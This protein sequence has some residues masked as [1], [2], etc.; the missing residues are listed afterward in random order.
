MCPSC[1]R[2]FS[3][4]EDLARHIPMHT[5]EKLYRCHQCLYRTDSRSNI[6]RHHRTHTGEKRH[7]CPVCP[8]RAGQKSDIRRHLRV[9]A[10]KM[11]NNVFRCRLCSANSPSAAA[12]ARHI[13][14][15]HAQA[16]T[17][18]QDPLLDE[19]PLAEPAEERVQASQ[20]GVLEGQSGS[21]SSMLGSLSAHGSGSVV[22]S[23][24]ASSSSSPSSSVLLLLPVSSSSSAVSILPLP[25][26][27][28]SS[29]SH[30]SGE[31]RKLLETSLPPAPSPDHPPQSPSPSD[32]KSSPGPSSSPSSPNPPLS[33]AEKVST[34]DQDQDD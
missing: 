6:Q 10:Q 25:P 28:S 13:L 4:V 9:H 14:D 2:T 8:Y 24:S 27:P 16:E 5:F 23:I 29:S 34:E 3:T 20:E 12:F 22:P 33:T 19:D 18:R 26:H 30:S 17:Q 7:A 15:A 32:S 11:Y 1:P 21:S 31:L